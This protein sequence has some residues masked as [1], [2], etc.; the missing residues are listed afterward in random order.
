[1]ASDFPQEV[2][3][4]TGALIWSI[5]DV[6][7]TLSW[8]KFYIQGQPGLEKAVRHPSPVVWTL[9]CAWHCAFLA[10]SHHSHPVLCP[11]LL[12]RE[13]TWSIYCLTEPSLVP[14]VDHRSFTVSFPTTSHQHRAGQHRLKGGSAL[15]AVI[16]GPPG[17]ET[18]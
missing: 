16:T 7:I 11:L 13:S 4:G 6:P 14:L 8:L 17:S 2:T 5:S 15:F 1:M 9:P 18:V 12:Y 3:L 10:H